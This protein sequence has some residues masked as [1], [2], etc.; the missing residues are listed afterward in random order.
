MH[1]I[2]RFTPL[3]W[4]EKCP[5]SVTYY[6]NGPLRTFCRSL[7]R[8]ST[9]HPSFFSP[10]EPQPEILLVACTHSQFAEGDFEIPPC[11]IQ[12]RT[13]ESASAVRNNQV[14]VVVVDD[15]EVTLLFLPLKN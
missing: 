1:K 5:K 14:V 7:L 4:S 10:L 8:L 12:N 11:S 3:W 15:V 13:V 2:W 9:T 6:L